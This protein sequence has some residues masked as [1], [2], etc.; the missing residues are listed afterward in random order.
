MCVD[1]HW[2]ILA[3]L[4]PLP[5]RLEWRAPLVISPMRSSFSWIFLSATVLFSIRMPAAEP[6]DEAVSAV[7]KLRT[8]SEYTWDVSTGKSGEWDSLPRTKHGAMTSTGEMIL[9]QIWPD[10]LVLETIT[11]PN[12]A[13]VVRTPD[14]WY[15]K[16]ELNELSRKPKRGGSQSKWLR[17]ATDAF[18]PP[19]PEEEL[20]H[21]LNDTTSCERS[22]DN[23]DAT[24]SE[25]GATYW[26]GSTR[27]V[28][29]ATGTVHLRLR[30]GLIREC[31]IVAE[32]EQPVD[33]AGTNFRPVAFE[34][35]LTFNYS[36]SAP[37]IPSEA[38]QKLDAASPR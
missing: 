26:L 21:L 12:G 15:T 30:D 32:G 10:G 31:H 2:R 37:P 27:L 35:T 22:G 20:T 25:R 1:P 16:S 34:S 9:E 24:L 13:A 18:E 3:A 28:P 8:R 5:H 19:T 23:L 33:Y 17:F 36:A 4:T 14:G 7:M 11:R 38:K 29:R 6:A